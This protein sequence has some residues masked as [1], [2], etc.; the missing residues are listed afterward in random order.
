MSR[1]TSRQRT[2]RFAA[3]GRAAFGVVLKGYIERLRPPG[4]P[5]PD[6][7]TVEYLER[8]VS[9]VTDLRR[10]LDYLE[11]RDD[12]DM[13]RVVFYG[14]SAGA[15][16]GLILAAVETR[17]RAVGMMGAGLVKTH[18]LRLPPANPIN[19]AP[20]IR[21]PTLLLQGRYDEDT[22]LKT[23][24]EPFFKLLSEPKRLVV[25][26]GGHVAPPEIVLTTV[27]GWLDQIL[28]PVRRQ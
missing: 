19:M 5:V 28:G 20:H 22:P 6:R 16:T 17:Y 26:D 27:G 23:H 4:T 24:T 2:P 9:R 18:A 3:T 10:G 12:L 13:S 15:Q 7:T 21:A 1:G 14:P 11:T 25:Y 8:I